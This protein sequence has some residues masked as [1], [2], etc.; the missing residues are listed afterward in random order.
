LAL[1][2]AGVAALVGAFFWYVFLRGGDFF[3]ILL[4]AVIFGVA[5]GY[6]T[7]LMAGA[8]GPPT[9]LLAGGAVIVGILIR[10][11]LFYTDLSRAGAGDF[12]RFFIITPRYF[13]AL[14]TAVAI[15]VIVAGFP[16]WVPRWRWGRPA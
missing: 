2:G 11:V 4:A 8:A 10:D 3:S 7:T 9:R 13:I 6:L 1:A 5:A 14:V 16:A 12:L 15:A